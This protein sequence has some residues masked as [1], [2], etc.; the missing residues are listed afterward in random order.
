M[1]HRIYLSSG[2]DFHCREDEVIS[3]AGIDAGF[4]FPVACRNGLCERC[5]GRLVRGHVH[6][7]RYNRTIHAGERQAERVLYC[8]AT[9]LSDCEINVP[10]VVVPGELPVHE[11][12][13]QILEV[14]PL[15]HDV[16][17]VWLRLPA[18]RQVEWYAGQYLELL[19]PD[20]AAPFSIAS[21]PE[22]DARELELHVRHNEDNPTSMEIITA[23]E[24]DLTIPVRL[25][26]GRRYID[27]LPDRP[28]WFICGSTGFAPVKAMVEHLRNTG[29]DQEVRVFWGARTGAD[30]YLP[31]MP[32]EWAA[33]MPNLSYQAVLSD[34]GKDGRLVHE[35]A[36]EQLTDAAAPL[37]FVGGSPAMAWA[38]YDA[39]VEA[40]VPGDNI[41]SDVYDYAPR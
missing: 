13:C 39:L 10:D 31:E 11:V 22:E 8:L 5:A 32:E 9:P 2:E 28:V 40:G 38:V 35:V 19:M 33:E 41:H 7:N 24:T 26:G 1:T 29:F 37:F 36:L 34:E 14:D 3:D 4:R 15:N 27:A 12:S 17:R 21:A 18:G 6:L 23:L 16:S 25:P 30:I 20:G